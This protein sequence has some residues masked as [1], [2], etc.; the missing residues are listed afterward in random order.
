MKSMTCECGVA[1]QGA[2]ENDVTTKMQSH[3]HN[4]HPDQSA[5]HKKMLHQAEKT[6]QDVAMA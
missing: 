6:I 2:S 5:E 1:V 4:D 3:L